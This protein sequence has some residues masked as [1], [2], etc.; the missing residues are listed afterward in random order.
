[1]SVNKISCH[2]YDSLFS[3]VTTNKKSNTKNADCTQ[4]IQKNALQTLQNNSPKHG[5]QEPVDS[6][7]SMP[8]KES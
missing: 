7:I 6:D 4:L 3:V 1:M 5:K 2:I 8:L